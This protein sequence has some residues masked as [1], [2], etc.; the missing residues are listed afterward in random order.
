MKTYSIKPSDIVRIWYVIDASEASLGRVATK[1]AS[2][3]TGK[4][5]PMFSSHIDCGDYV[6]IINA[7]NLRVTGDK[8]TQKMY[9]H[10]SG[11]PSGLTET[12]LKD[13]LAAD[14]TKVMEKA[15]MGMLPVNKLRPARRLRLKI[16]A[17]SEHQHE[18]QKPVTL[19]LK[20]KSV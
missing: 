7:S 16:Y 5:K 17:G 13:K 9:Y 4:G 20:E 15:I 2:L 19:S 18:P 11:F 6:I 1:A 10:H 8:L 14:P 3:L 12:M